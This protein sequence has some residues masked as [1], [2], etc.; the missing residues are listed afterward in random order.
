MVHF[1]YPFVWL[2]CV[3]TCISSFA[4]LNSNVS[5]EPWDILWRGGGGGDTRLG[6]GRG[7]C[8][9]FGVVFILVWVYGLGVT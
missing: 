2:G 8:L 3:G 9:I 1:L 6:T 7:R 4:L 5:R